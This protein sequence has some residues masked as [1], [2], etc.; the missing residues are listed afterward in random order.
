MKKISAWLLITSLAITLTA[1][2][3]TVPAAT[4][5]E[6]NS[7][8]AEQTLSESSLPDV[9]DYPSD[10]D[11][12]DP[13]NAKVY[14]QQYM[15]P[16]SGI[17]VQSTIPKDAVVTTW[18]TSYGASTFVHSDYNVKNADVVPG[19]DVSYHNGTIDWDKVKKDGIKFVIL[20]AGYGGLT[21]GTPNE[22]VKFDT[23]IKEAQ[24]A[25]LKVGVYFYSQA[26]TEAEAKKE[27]A[28]TLNVIKG[29][30]LDLPVYFDY[31]DYPGSYLTKKNLSKS[32]K[33]ACATAFCDAIE[34]SGYEAQV[35]AGSNW[36]CTNLD[37]EKLGEK[38]GIWMA[39]YYDSSVAY[40][41]RE[42]YDSK[43][44]RY[45]GKLNIWQCSEYGKVSGISTRVDM[46][47]MYQAKTSSGSG[48]STTTKLTAKQKSASTSAV[49]VS[50][51]KMPDATG[52]QVYYSTLHG[53][54]YKLAE[55]VDASELSAR[56]SKLK[57]GTEY[58]VKVRPVYK[59]DGKTSYG[60][61]CSEVTT[62]TKNADT[63]KIK[64][65]AK[66]MMRRWAGTKYDAMIYVPKS[67][68]LTVV[69][70]T[71]DTSGKTWYRVAYKKSGLTYNGYIK[72]SDTTYHVDKVAKVQQSSSY[73]TSVKVK[74]DKVAH[75]D[76]YR[77]YRAEAK[78]GTYK[79]IKTVAATTTSYANKGLRSG[80]E[81][82]Y[83]V[84]AYQKI[85]G[86][87]VTGSASSIAVLRTKKTKFKVKT[88]Y[89]M[90]VRKYAGTSYNIITTVQKG[91]KL[92]ATYKTRDKYG[93]LW[94]KVNIKDGAKDYIGYM[95]SAYVSV[96]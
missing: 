71:K 81:Y 34:K 41:F 30:K 72:Q 2:G 64:T 62:R 63:I 65:T 66:T 47:Y 73:A 46:N 42:G 8:A 29:Y 45:A 52:Y 17:A 84:K 48:N 37:G 36:L 6:N 83:K 57:A 20:R 5:S 50:W 25:G 14:E 39:R 7:S 15:T 38:Y 40:S 12:E 9:S 61:Y 26:T 31:E 10:W 70:A 1:G 78:N 21:Y 11:P 58:Y 90:N 68:V 55:T 16:E 13:M 44:S 32:K 85:S 59:K 89:N 33:T 86:K 60:S 54:S 80:T 88:R 77:I 24:K 67:T 3:I 43:D 69:S 28:Y 93:R 4:A 74:W 91:K 51:N 23:Y 35:Y 76:G 56:I 94:Y 18:P 75:A 79:K 82:Y 53:Q 22:D 92:E 96:M 27:A 49:R 95:S 87:T 19:I